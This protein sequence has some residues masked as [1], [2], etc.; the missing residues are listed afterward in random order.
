MGLFGKKKEDIFEMQVARNLKGIELEKKGDLDEA[1]K[2]Y[3]QNIKENFEGNHPYD[4]LSIIYR[5]RGQIKDEIRVLEKAIWVFE[6]IVS[7]ER[8]DRQ[9]KLMKFKNRLEKAKKL[10]K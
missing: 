2:L 7:M 5:K 6:N 1:I 8:A 10:M 3:E 9:V 4:R